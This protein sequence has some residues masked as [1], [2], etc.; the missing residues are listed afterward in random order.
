MRAVILAGGK[1]TRLAALRPGV[2][3]PLVPVAGVPVLT[4]QLLA[5]KKEGV[6]DV[7]LVTCHLAE[8]VEAAYGDGA[9]LGVRLRYF[10]EPEPLGTAG[11][12][13]YLGLA[14]DFLLLSGDLVFDFDLAAMVRFHR[15][16]GAA[17]TL[18]AH[19]NSHPYDS[20]LLV[21]CPDGRV[22]GFLPREGKPEVYENLCNAG[23]QILSPAL[24]K[25][26]PLR[27]KAD[28]DRDLLRPAVEAGGVYAY[29]SCE[30]VKDMGT[31]ERLK[32]VERDLFWDL[33]A[34]RRRGIPKRAVF[35]DRDG[36]L[37]VY[38][39]FIAD[40]AA[41]ELLPGVGAA[42]GRL[43]AL[44]FLAVL[45]TNQPVVAR[46]MC[47]METLKNIHLRLQTLLG[48]EG[49][50]LDGLYVCPHHPDRGFPGEDISLK[51]DCDCRKPKP[52]LLLR[53]AAELNIDLAASYMAGDTLRDVETAKN[54]GCTPVF[55]RCGKAEPEPPGVVTFD[56]L[57]AFVRALEKEERGSPLK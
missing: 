21:A 17:A 20:A 43:N 24:L 5:L 15:E 18:F 39:G 13:P 32:A 27:G 57:P 35:L 30:Y 42:V 52:G 37:N 50:Y 45:A 54:A 44:G 7:T 55:L 49:A 10:R 36:T 6:T 2:P 33:P 22:T 1:G 19:P 23:I 38:R 41:L 11:A 31:P 16:K 25:S 26:F 56:D 4:R 8:Q 53:A 47:S 46:G 28:L 29:K 51:I 34:G 9:A 12:L 3:K 14:D 40:P 48:K